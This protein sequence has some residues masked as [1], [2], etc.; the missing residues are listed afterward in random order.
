MPFSVVPGKP[1][2]APPDSRADS[3]K[4]EAAIAKIMGGAPE[5]LPVQDPTK[6][7]PE[8]MSVVAPASPDPS[9]AKNYSSEGSTDPS[10]SGEAPPSESKPPEQISS[11]YAQLARKEK[12]IRDQA[13]EVKSKEDA[14]AAREAAIAEKEKSLEKA[15]NLDKRLSD[16]P[17]S[18]LQ[19]KGVSY[20]QLTER[21]LSQPD[22][23]SA[24]YRSEIKS[25]QEKIA[26]LE[27]KHE[28]SRRFQETQQQ[29]SYK[30]AV[31]QIKTEAKQLVYTDPAFETIKATNSVDDVVELI[32]KTFQQDGV[33]MSVEEA[34]KQVEDYLLA[35]A[36][37]LLRISK[38]Q[39]KFKPAEQKP[40]AASQQA[41]PAA[42]KQVTLTNS[43][44]S[45]SKMS[46]R[47]RAIRAFANQ[48]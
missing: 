10:A 11:Q 14:L 25:L 15:M 23:E 36:E 28:E 17:W 2:Y 32:E 38:I 24:A 40:A 26:A 12:A 46:A 37:K 5:A 42:P 1:A 43:M 21:A 4:R 44:G 13:R 9:P 41:S 20:D 16:D 48:K 35:E 7:A 30:Q 47:E 34:A 39:Q 31:A 18:V 29:E 6:V 33:L 22:P 27:G 45:V 19:E 3:A 8:E